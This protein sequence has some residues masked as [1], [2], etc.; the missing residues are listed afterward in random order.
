MCPIFEHNKTPIAHY[1]SCTKIKVP[2]HVIYK[3]NPFIEREE[4]ELCR[5]IDYP[6][7]VFKSRRVS[8]FLSLASLWSEARHFFRLKI[9][10]FVLVGTI[11]TMNFHCSGSIMGNEWTF[12]NIY[13]WAL[14]F[15]TN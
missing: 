1:A 15:V 8:T 6:K 5:T 12:S 2:R 13:C 3:I 7:K 10:Y 9:I 14:G 11:F 4:S